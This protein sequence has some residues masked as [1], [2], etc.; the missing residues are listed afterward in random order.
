MENIP[1]QAL[2]AYGKAIEET[3][4]ILVLAWKKITKA[5]K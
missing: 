2:E 4:T 5:L 1:T 3:R